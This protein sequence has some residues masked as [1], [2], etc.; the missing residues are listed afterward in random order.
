M[1]HRTVSLQLYSVRNALET[2]PVGTIDRV[3]ALGFE[4]VEAGYKYLTAYDGLLEAIHRHA[5]ATPT[6]TASL[7]EVADRA[8]VWEVAKRLGAH[9]VVETF[10]PEQHWTSVADVDHV[11]AELNAASAEAA[12]Q[13]LRVGY[14]NHWWELET[15]FDGER[16]LD[17]LIA[18]L[19]PAVVLE[20]DA[21]WVAVGGSDPVAFVA[22]NADRVRFLHLKDGPIDRD[23]SHQVPAGT[24]SLPI[25]GILAAASSLEGAVVEF[26]E[27]AGDVFEAS[28]L[29]RAFLER[30]VNGAGAEAVA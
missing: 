15:R 8:P 23:N 18:R 1:A 20:I 28:G 21:Y 11:A 22:D 9:T 25:A 4:A 27:F 14:H 12:A 3:A 29:S 16:A 10:V 17:L 6:L 26:D 7:F 13:G 2:D 30:A 5:L 24:G 19:D